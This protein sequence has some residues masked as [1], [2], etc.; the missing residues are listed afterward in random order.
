LK[1]LAAFSAALAGLLC[2]WFFTERQL[3]PM[4]LLP[5]IL[6]GLGVYFHKIIVVAL[7]GLVAAML[8]LFVPVMAGSQEPQ[9]ENQP[10]AVEQQFDLLESVEWVQAKIEQI[11]QGIKEAVTGIPQSRKMA[12]I[13]AVVIV[14]LLG[15]WSWRLICAATCS[16]IGTLLVCSG[17]ILLLLYKGSEPFNKIIEG[18]QFFALIAIVMTTVGVVLQLLLCPAVPKKSELKKELLNSGDKK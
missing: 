14:G 17:M 9:T 15:L 1:S 4:I 18:R 7:G 13:A 3:M 5:V 8:V 6:A 16:V 11:R 12:A 10:P 2:A